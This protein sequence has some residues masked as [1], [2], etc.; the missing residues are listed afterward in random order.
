MQQK[1][2]THMHAE[3]Y[4]NRTESETSLY[5]IILVAMLLQKDY[6][7]Y[8]WSKHKITH[9]VPTEGDNQVAAGAYRKTTACLC[10]QLAI[11]SVHVHVHTYTSHFS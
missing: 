8:K 5:F 10:W 9:V 4:T 7:A 6:L 1:R 11:N 3:K 2:D